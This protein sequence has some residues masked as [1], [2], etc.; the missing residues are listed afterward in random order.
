MFTSCRCCRR[1]LLPCVPAGSSLLDCLRARHP[2]GRVG[3]AAM[4]LCRWLSRWQLFFRTRRRTL[5]LLLLTSTAAFSLLVLALLD[6][7]ERRSTAAGAGDS[8]DQQQS[9][10]CLRVTRNTPDLD[11][12]EVLPTLNFTA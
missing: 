6:T 9:Y 12:T 11:L 7:S 3:S 5:R 4:S 8:S 2:T 10:T 1:L